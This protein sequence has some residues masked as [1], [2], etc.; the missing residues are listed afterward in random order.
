MQN[1]LVRDEPDHTRLRAL[2][3][4]AFTP[5]LVENLRSRIETLT[6]QFLD[7]VAGNGRM[8]VIRDYALPLP[9]TI[10]AEM[11][12]VPPSDR[13]RFLR[14]STAVID[15]RMRG[16]VTFLKGVPSAFAFIRYIR[17]LIKLRRERPDLISALVA[18]EEQ[19]DKLSEDELVGMIFLLLVAGYETTVNLIGNGTLAL[20]DNPAEMEILRTQPSQMESAVEEL[21]RYDSPLDLATERFARCD[22]EIAGVTIP[23]GAIVFAA[24]ASANR[25]R[26]QFERPDEL[27]L[28]RDP[29]HHL[30]FGKGIHYCLGAPLARLEGQIAFTTLLRR[31]AELR[32]AVPRDA[33]RWR[34]S[35]S[36]RALQALPIEFR[37]STMLAA[38]AQA[39]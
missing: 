30:A 10:I 11:L 37:A 38:R 21:L 15:L 6:E 2:V 35:L 22:I 28:G 12:G 16:G 32:L 19:G 20:L 7:R 24:L 31:F 3:H 25:D 17:D 34:T 39:T 13:D 26:Q 27:D 23:R 14:W 29:N 33:L 4:K 18:A 5:R 1:M 8:D 36:L 9:S